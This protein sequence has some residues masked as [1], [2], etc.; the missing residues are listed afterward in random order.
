LG[1]YWSDIAPVTVRFNNYLGGIYPD[2]ITTT[3]SPVDCSTISDSE[4]LGTTVYGDIILMK[5]PDPP[6]NLVEVVAETDETKMTFEW[7]Y[8]EDDT[9]SLSDF[10]ASVREPTAYDGGSPITHFS[11]YHYDL[12]QLST[13]RLDRVEDEATYLATEA[14]KTKLLLT[15]GSKYKIALTSS[16]LL[17][18]SETETTV[19]ILQ[20]QEPEFITEGETS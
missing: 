15:K 18:E 3:V 7:E 13:S 4:Y 16:N 17:G 20:A 5:L 6:I 11:I 2:Q 9:W 8:P 10:Y 1:F 19:E 12:T 14:T